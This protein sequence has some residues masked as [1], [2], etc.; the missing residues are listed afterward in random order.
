MTNTTQLAL[1]EDLV[2]ERS[3]RQ[4]EPEWLLQRRLEA[5]REF[6]DLEMPSPLDEVWRRTDITG[7]DLEKALD[8]LQLSPSRAGIPPEFLETAG[9]D[10]LLAVQDGVAEERFRSTGLDQNVV[11]T[12]LSRAAAEHPDL[13]RDLLSSVIAAD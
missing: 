8:S 5:W 7:L 6:N 13:V 9:I 2:R 4:S 12:G 10:A 11:F 3:R 1:S